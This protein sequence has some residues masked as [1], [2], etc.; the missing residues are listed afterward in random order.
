MNFDS[1]FD[2]EKTGEYEDLINLLYVMD[3]IYLNKS[4]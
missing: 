1:D 4:K 2:L 3:L